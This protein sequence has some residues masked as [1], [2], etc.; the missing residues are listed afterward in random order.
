MKKHLAYLFMPL[1]ILM[2]VEF[3]CGSS[4]QESLIEYSA[5]LLFLG[6][7]LYY[8]KRVYQRV[9]RWPILLLSVAHFFPV[10]Q[11]E[12]FWDINELPF[13][14]GKL[15][16][17]IVF[18][19]VYA[20]RTKFYQ[21]PKSRILNLVR[22]LKKTSIYGFIINNIIRYLHSLI[23]EILALPNLQDLVG[24]KMIL[25]FVVLQAPYLFA[26]SAILFFYIESIANFNKKGIWES[27]IDSI[28]S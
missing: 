3:L 7:L 21:K 2:L 5:R 28:G 8:P 1:G 10:W 14:V 15:C 4:F 16:I 24:I 13:L 23:G 17:L 12:R 6:F 11:L 19:Y 26:L 27:K 20:F 22:T 25:K 9:G 18:A